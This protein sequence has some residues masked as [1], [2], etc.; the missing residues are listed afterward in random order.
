MSIESLAS[1]TFLVLL[2]L[3]LIKNRE[4]LQVQKILWPLL[5]FAMYKTK[6]GLKQMDSI[7]KK[8]PKLVD[9]LSKAGVY[10][11]TLGIFVIAWLLIKGLLDIFLAPAAAASVSLVLPFKV[12]GGFYV[13][14][15]YWIISIFFIATIHEFCHGVVARLH[16]VPI[17]SSG[18]AFLGVLVPV[19]PAAFVEPDE[20]TLAKRTKM[21]KL[22]VFAAGPFSNIL[23]GGLFLVLFILL[24]VPVAS[25]I[26]QYE[27]TQIEGF[28]GENSSAQMAGVMQGSTIK[29]VDDIEILTVDNLSAALKTKKVGDTVNVM[30]TNGTFNI[31]LGPDPQNASKPYLGVLVSQDQSIKPSFEAKYGSIT[32]LVI[33]WFMGLLYWLYALSLGIGLFNLVPIGPVDGGQMSRELF[34][35]I[36]K[37]EKTAMKWWSFVSMFFFAIIMIT[38]FTGFF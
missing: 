30:T 5:Y 6:L 14:F 8:H 27:G 34:R 32:A 28:S 25:N 37:N 26:I 35:A 9:F 17:K 10:I 16:N 4:K 13:P 24:S 29:A 38:L 7:S 18:F 15:F 20:K 33:L 23:T 2:S 12:K 36:F 11:G 19:I 22:S 1:I 21:Q 3:F 31:M